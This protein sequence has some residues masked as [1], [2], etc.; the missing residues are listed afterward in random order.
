MFLSNTKDKSLI[1]FGNLENLL[2]LI[3]SIFISSK[4]ISKNIYFYL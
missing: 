3:E 2:H 1:I 4:F